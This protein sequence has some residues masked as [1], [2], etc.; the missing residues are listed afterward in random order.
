MNILPVSRE[1]ALE[2]RSYTERFQAHLTDKHPSIELSPA[3]LALVGD[4]LDFIRKTYGDP[5]QPTYLQ[6]HNDNHSYGV[7]TRTL[8]L[9]DTWQKA[10]DTQFDS[11]T[12][13]LAAIASSTHDIVKGALRN[14]KQLD[15]AT[16]TDTISLHDDDSKSD[17]QLSAEY[18]IRSMHARGNYTSNDRR[19]VAM[20]IVA[21]EVTFDGV[22]VSLKRIREAANDPVAASL[23][24]ADTN[25]IFARSSSVPS[26]IGEIVSDLSLE[27]LRG[28]DSTVEHIIDTAGNLLRY[29]SQFLHDRQNDYD[30]ISRHLIEEYGVSRR[31]EALKKTF[32]TSVDAALTF[33]GTLETNIDNVVSEF[34]NELLRSKDMSLAQQNKVRHALVRALDNLRK[35]T[36]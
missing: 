20:A 26:A 10:F 4:N 3:G 23:V 12:F 19:R 1:R 6:Y 32:D 9:L 16:G 11:H 33:A 7:T 27:A 25:D 34:R 18:A 5:E 14:T 28:R 36:I 13:E 35:S 17:E 24:I 2:D 30:M 29:Q 31:Y 21:T 22:S 15:I 8:W